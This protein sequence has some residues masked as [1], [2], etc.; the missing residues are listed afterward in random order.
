MS[1]NQLLSGTIADKPW[2][3]IVANDIK[4]NTLTTT[5][6]SIAGLTP[7]KIVQTDAKGALSSSTLGIS[8]AFVNGNL[9]EYNA[10]S[11]SIVDSGVAAD[12]VILLDAP[13]QTITGDLKVNGIL[14]TGPFLTD[15]NLSVGP[16]TNKNYWFVDTKPFINIPPG[17][18]AASWSLLANKS[19]TNTNMSGLVTVTTSSATQ[20][21][22][23]S[24]SVYSFSVWVKDGVPGNTAVGTPINEGK[25]IIVSIAQETLGSVCSFTVLLTSDAT[26]G[27]ATGVAKIEFLA[28]GGTNT[29]DSWFIG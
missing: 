7:N 15:A 4:T 1:L 25:G 28:G 8:G 10:G 6:V 26:V 2:C 12:K 20:G 16:N 17:N 19:V 29:N 13:D 27:A 11:S 3:N 5:N 9:L 18:T 24:V 21:I 23:N 22:G 14:T